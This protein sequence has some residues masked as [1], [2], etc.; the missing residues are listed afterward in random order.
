MQYTTLGHTGLTVSRICLGCMSYGDPAWRPWV[1]DEDAAR[2]FFRQAI[3]AGITFFDTADMYSL[4][5]SEAITGRALRE[6]ANREEIVVATKVYN[7]M[8]SGPNMRGLGRKHVIQA[9]EASLR[10]LG[11]ETID[12]YQIHRFDP[13]VPVDE[14]LRALEDLVRAGKVRYL[15]A[16]SGMSWRLA[17]ALSTSERHGWARFV[18][19]QN[20]YNLVYREEEREMIPLCLQE[21][22]GVIPWSPLARGLLARPR[23]ATSQLPDSGTTRA[24]SDDYAR[25]MYDQPSD[26]DVVDAVER[27]A[28]A[29]GVGMAEV[30]LAWVLSR[31]GVTAPIV[32]ATKAHHLE[33]AVRAL[34]VALTAEEKAAL[35]APYRPH[36]VR[37]Y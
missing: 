29:R 19:M 9:C 2:P 17:Q 33:A 12:L 32:G 28:S 14:T 36:P 23:P 18:S 11:V 26:W 13:A 3:E 24:G 34:D 21:G 20:H 4:G 6:L 16:S 8:G 31:P 27:V 7:A 37:G 10:R 25:Q 22:I 15:G 35:E 5:A 30:A 1:L